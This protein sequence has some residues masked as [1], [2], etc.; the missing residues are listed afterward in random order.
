MLDPQPRGARVVRAVAAAVTG[1]ALTFAAAGCDS[2]GDTPR[3]SRP[4]A[5]V[6][7][8]AASAPLHA[9]VTHVGG[10][11][12]PRQRAQLARSAKVPIQQYVDHAFLGTY[13]RTT[14]RNAFS[15]FTPGAARSARHDAATLT[16]RRFAGAR[17]V[18]AKR[19][20]AFLSV[21]APKGRV[22]GATARVRM[23]FVADEGGDAGRK[24]LAVTGRLLLTKEH[25]RWRIFGY[26]LAAADQPT[27]KDGGS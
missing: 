19:L 4:P 18:T 20:T 17:S 24:R 15:A 27:Q 13:P 1:V 5:P 7:S 12:S 14:W 23:T 25:G 26:D 8:A 11:L 3:A 21:L 10:R 9:K 22:V 2:G 16:G 6:T